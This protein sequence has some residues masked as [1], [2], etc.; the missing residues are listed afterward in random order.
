MQSYKQQENSNRKRRGISEEDV[1]SEAAKAAYHHKAYEAPSETVIEY[2]R[3][4]K[5]KKNEKL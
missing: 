5:G 2:L 4:L 1:P 3:K